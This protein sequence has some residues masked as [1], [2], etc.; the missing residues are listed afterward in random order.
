MIKNKFLNGIR[1]YIQL[2]VFVMT[3]AIGFQFY[4]YVSQLTG[5]GPVT[6][7][8]P[9][10]VEG[11]LPI[12]ALMGW[13]HFITTGAWDI[14]HPAAMVFL[15]FA[16]FVSFLLPKSF[17]SWFCP[18]GTLSEWIWKFGEIKLGKNYQI[19]KWIDL[20]LRGLKYGLLVFFVY[21]ISQM[22]AADIGS[23]LESPYYKTADVKMLYFFARISGFAA[24]VLVLLVVLSI[25]F[26]NF[27]CRYACP[28]GALLGIFSI[29]S[30]SR[31]R[32]N[33]ETCTNCNKCHHACPFHL[34]VNQKTHILS[35]D[36]SG[37]M[38][39]VGVCPSK[40][41]LNLKS[42]LFDKIL[43]I[44][45]V[46]LLVVIIFFSMVYFATITGHWRSQL[47]ENELRMWIKQ[48]NIS[49]SQHPSV[50]FKRN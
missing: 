20:P 29:F 22:N 39:C 25:F 8:R 26:R 36:C 49:E 41:T 37:C 30:P 45:Q 7:P 11:F 33:P 38:D 50:Q 24:I 17:C 4:I 16:V 12:G 46:G 47:P 23:F 9:E 6:V 5:S 32:R 28:Y 48:E 42:L 44:P 43:N 40:D 1:N 18:V 13:K 15:G 35:P 31:I 34:P 27:W 21:I 2:A 3:A 10:G 19:H 14:I